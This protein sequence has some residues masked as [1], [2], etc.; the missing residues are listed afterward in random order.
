MNPQSLDPAATIRAISSR[1]SPAPVP[2]AGRSARVAC[3]AAAP[4]ELGADNPAAGQSY[5]YIIVGGG[6]AG[7]VLANRL[8]ADG[9]KRVLVLE[10]GAG[11]NSIN[12]RIP[13]AIT[14]LFRSALDW[15]LFSESQKQLL[16][17]QV[18]LAR[19]R[20]LGG[21]SSTNATLYHRGAAADYD[22]WGVPG[23]AADDVLPW[24]VRSETNADKPPGKY[25][26]AEG[27]MRVESPRYENYLHD[28]FFAAA[29][30]WGLPANPDFNDWSRPQE[31]YGEFQVTQDKGRRAD[32]YRQYLKPALGRSNL[33]VVTECTVTR[34]AT[35]TS[36]AEPRAV[37][38][39]FSLEG[40]STMRHR[41]TASLAPGGEVIM[42]AGA[43]HT[44]HILQLSGIGA[45]AMLAQHGIASVAD[46][47][48]V[49]QG[50]QDQPACLTA[51]PLKAKYEG[52]SLTDHIYSPKGN[53]RKRALAAF[54][55]L[56]KGPLTSTG[57]DHGAFLRTGASP[58]PDLQIRF[59]PG[60]A[61][62]PD[63]VS[64]YVRFAK[65]QEQGKKWPSG[66][67]FQLI[68]CRPQ[69]RGSVGLR[70]AEPFDAPKV[71]VGYLSDER[72]ADLATLK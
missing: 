3:R 48:G 52:T 71:D 53:L 60:M 36:A 39:E 67:T 63:G 11:N 55:L 10:A 62:D 35:E 6:T 40:P 59:V 66:V 32:C 68:A 72:G 23:W 14:K 49:G 41:H 5:D 51:A 54:F 65:F 34:V 9:S 12:V 70:S 42:S 31:G 46:L 47:P 50:L 15:N 7:C 17:R 58:L 21:S 18:Y 44:P 25:H 27:S 64:T 69:S 2:H 19:G 22:A 26:G 29:A 45:A 16:D 13:A 4:F 61:L 38:V 43:V 33:Q 30:A 8:T 57:C 28:A 56:G 24:F 1:L 37:G 20:L